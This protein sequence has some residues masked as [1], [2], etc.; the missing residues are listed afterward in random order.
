MNMMSNVSMAMICWL[1]KKRSLF[2]SRVMNSSRTMTVRV[3][4]KAL[5]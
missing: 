3:L 2:C 5:W 4:R 1:E